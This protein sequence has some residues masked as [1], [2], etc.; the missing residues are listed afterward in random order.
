MDTKYCYKAAVVAI[1]KNTKILI[2][3]GKI[4]NYLH[5]IPLPDCN[6][7][8]CFLCECTRKTIMFLSSILFITMSFFLT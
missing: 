7:L 4:Q 5:C 2:A 3:F 1:G 6:I 8:K